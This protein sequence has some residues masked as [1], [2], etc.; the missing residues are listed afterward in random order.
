MYKM[1]INLGNRYEY[2]NCNSLWAADYLCNEFVRKYRNIEQ[3]ELIA[4]ESGE[5]VKIYKRV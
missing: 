5:I 3:I 1:K 4:V 2:R